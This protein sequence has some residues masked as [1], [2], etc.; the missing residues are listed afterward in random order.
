MRNIYTLYR[1]KHPFS[2]LLN[3]LDPTSTDIAS[4]VLNNLLET[5]RAGYNLGSNRD[6]DKDFVLL[7][8]IYEIGDFLEDM[9]N[10]DCYDVKPKHSDDYK[11]Y[12]RLAN[13]EESK[14]WRVANNIVF[15]YM[16]SFGILESY[17]N[18]FYNKND[19]YALYKSLRDYIDPSD[20]PSYVNGESEGELEDLG[21]N[22][23]TSYYYPNKY[24][25]KVGDIPHLKVGG[26]NPK[27]LLYVRRKNELQTNWSMNYRLELRKLVVKDQRSK[28]ALSGT[29]TNNSGWYLDFGKVFGT[30]NIY[31]E[32]YAGWTT[33]ISYDFQNIK[34]A[35]INWDKHPFYHIYK[36]FYEKALYCQIL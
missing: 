26:L 9:F 17:Y 21:I 7:H 25:N 28:V 8:R 10:I 18:E 11:Y 32:H 30:V 3:I 14:D 5:V 35:E 36:E 29:E 19:A 34:E 22:F 16:G 4:L 23:G 24:F 31:E 1:E 12:E 33:Y 6:Y 27:D 15:D 2:R 13:V 20:L